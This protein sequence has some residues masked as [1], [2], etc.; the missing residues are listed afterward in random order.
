MSGWELL[1]PL[2][3]AWAEAVEAYLLTGW[4]LSKVLQS[5]A[6]CVTISVGGFGIYQ[7]WRF[8]EKRLG[9]RLSEYLKREETRLAGARTSLVTALQKSERTKREVEPLFSNA[10]LSRALRQLKWG[11]T[12]PAEQGLQ[13]ALKLIEEKVNIAEERAV[14]HRR[15]KGCCSPPAWGHRGLQKGSRRRVRTISESSGSQSRRCGCPP[16]RR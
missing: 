8:A 5:I 14:C 9:E 4:D 3:S 16:V 13:S 2:L 12:K 6:A 7:G 1:L 11:R 15:Q 10:A